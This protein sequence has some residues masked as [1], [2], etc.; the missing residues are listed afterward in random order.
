M[1]ETRQVRLYGW[2]GHHWTRRLLGMVDEPAGIPCKSAMI[3]RDQAV[4]RP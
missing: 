1:H 3:E 4:L 2:C